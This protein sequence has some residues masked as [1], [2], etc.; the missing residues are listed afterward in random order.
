MTHKPTHPASSTVILIVLGMLSAF[1]P[2]ATDLYLPGFHLLAVSFGVGDDSIQN[3]LS[4]FFLGLAVGQAFY[5]PLIDRWG[6]RL[7]LLVGIGLYVA[8]TIVCLGTSDIHVFTVARFL[9]AV[10]G[11][12]GMIV[13][14]AIVN[15][16][17]EER[18]SAKA[19]SLLMIVMTVGPIVAPTIGGLIL[20]V[21][22]WRFLFVLILLFGLACGALTIVFLPETLPKEKRKTSGLG[23]AFSDYWRLLRCPAFLVPTLVGGLAQAS[24]FAF[25][26]GSSF[27]FIQ[28]YGVSEQTF[29]YLFG[30]ISFGLIVAAQANRMM[31]EWWNT[32]TLLSWS[33]AFNLVSGLVLLSVAATGHLFWLVAALWVTMASVAVIGSNSA[34]VAM[35]EAGVE[36]GSGSALIGVL[37]FGLA[38]AASSV[39]AALQNGTAYPMTGVIFACGLLATATW[40]L[41]RRLA[42]TENETAA[43]R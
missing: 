1:A 36:S 8:M 4:V 37:Q 25:I 15:D 32:R 11:C 27:V 3:T 14:R 41:G 38:F 21:A 22:N 39:V 28:K 23:S 24:L 13:G 34:A 18:D 6:R 16:L 43:L 30:A 33:L 19:L 20:A 42:A 5:G 12:A 26:G 10:G 2:M 29:G 40:M 7:P 17:F 35:T 9:Q 31:L